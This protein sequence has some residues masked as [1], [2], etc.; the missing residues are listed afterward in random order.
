MLTTVIYKTYNKKFN[1]KN[2]GHTQEK[3]IIIQFFNFL[4]I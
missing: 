2:A 1:L 3:V 4:F